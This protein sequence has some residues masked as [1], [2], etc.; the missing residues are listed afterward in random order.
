M[1][2][3]KARFRIKKLKKFFPLIS[4]RRKIFDRPNFFEINGSLGSCLKN[5]IIF[6]TDTLYG[7]K[8]C[9]KIENFRKF[10]KILEEFHVVFVNNSSAEKIFRNFFSAKM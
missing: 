3:R 7:V 10:R 9:I 2:T 5:L 6:G 1:L 8:I 4:D